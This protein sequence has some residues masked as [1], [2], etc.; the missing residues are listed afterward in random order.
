MIGVGVFLVLFVIICTIVIAVRTD[1]DKPQ[2]DERQV[3]VQYRGYKYAAFTGIILNLASAFI[4]SNQS[5][6]TAPAIMYMIAFICILVFVLYCIFKGV[7]FGIKDKWK[8][9]TVFSA[10]AGIIN[11]Y[12][13]VTQITRGSF[14]QD[15]KV[16]LENSTNLVIGI[17]FTAIAASTLIQHIRERVSTQ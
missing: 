4:V 16:T 1:P 2:Y 15:G 13:A 3:L 10:I 5:V 11:L 6:V 9:A 12:D 7:Y 8:S 17:F 14:L